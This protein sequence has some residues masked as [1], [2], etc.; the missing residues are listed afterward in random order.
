MTEFEKAV[1]KAL[2]DRDKTLS[3][4]ARELGITLPYLYDILRGNR[5]AKEQREKIN[6]ILG[7][8]E[9]VAS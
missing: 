4:L 2:I 5:K 8:R 9:E 1:R 7:L 3:W 6:R